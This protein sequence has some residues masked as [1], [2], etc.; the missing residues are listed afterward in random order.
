[1]RFFSCPDNIRYAAALVPVISKEQKEA[2]AAI[3]K[4]EI[5]SFAKLFESLYDCALS[6]MRVHAPRSVE[7]IIDPVLA[8]VL[9]FH[10]V[11]MIGES[12]VMSEA[13]TIPEA[14]CPLGGFL[15]Q[16]P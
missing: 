4:K 9:L 8:K 13:L 7:R 16:V 5:A 1:M 12:A 10:T 3:L 15:Y 11:G 14:D 6:V 2:I